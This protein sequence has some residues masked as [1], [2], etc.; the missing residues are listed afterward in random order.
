MININWQLTMYLEEINE[1]P[2]R[3]K[4]GWIK[5]TQKWQ[6]KQQQLLQTNKQK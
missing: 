6:D 1:P 2:R 5:V 3:K 4:K